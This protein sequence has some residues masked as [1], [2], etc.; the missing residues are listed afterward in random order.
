MKIHKTTVDFI[1][2]SLKNLKYCPY[3]IRYFNFYVNSPHKT[4][5]VE[6][7]VIFQNVVKEYVVNNQEISSFRVRGVNFR[8]SR[9][10]KRV[11]F[12]GFLL[13]KST[14]QILFMV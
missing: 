5:Y 3:E 10:R 4:A 9:K 2:V 8:H 6:T 14:W 1:S 7:T 13:K 11:N 12:Q